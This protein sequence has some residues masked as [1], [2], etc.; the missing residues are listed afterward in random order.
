MKR[1]AIMALTLLVA[2]LPALAETVTIECYGEVEYNQINSGAF[3]AVSSGD[4]VY[5]VFTVE[6]DDYIDSTSYGVR[7]YP[8]DLASFQLTIGAA[9][10]IG[11][12]DP[13][14][15]GLVTYFNLRNDDP[16]ADG[17][18]VANNP[19]WPMDFPSLDEPGSIDPW[20]NFHW[21]VG[22]EGTVLDSRD[23]LDAVG[24]YDYTGL[25]SF[26]TVIGDAWADAMGLVYDHMVISTDS[27]ATEQTTLT[28]VKALFE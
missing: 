7:S 15:N 12:V 20:F 18:F 23:V 3:A 6:S 1:F 11:L 10:P 2:A 13:Q 14:P 27:V 5:A 26:Y 8:V 21:E 9:G 4:Q 17:F 16:G 28:G 25:T 24:T 19:E 22:Y